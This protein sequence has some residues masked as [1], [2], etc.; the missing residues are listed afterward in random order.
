MSIRAKE[1]EIK[2]S[3]RDAEKFNFEDF[4]N[5]TSSDNDWG[6]PKTTFTPT[7]IH[8]WQQ[9]LD[10]YGS[11]TLKQAISPSIDLANKGLK[12]IKEHVNKV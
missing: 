11:I 6:N 8:A 3:G 10:K 2:N 5:T 4:I 9:L 12:K 1:E 7:I